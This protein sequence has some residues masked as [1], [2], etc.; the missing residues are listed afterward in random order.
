MKHA[1]KLPSMPKI[2]EWLQ[3]ATGDRHMDPRSKIEVDRWTFHMASYS[4]NICMLSNNFVLFQEDGNNLVLFVA[5]DKPNVPLAWFGYGKHGAE[6]VRFASFVA[7][8]SPSGDF[9]PP[10]SCA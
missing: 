5:D 10:P 4:I 9:D 8:E 6:E 2:W 3:K 7:M 1:T